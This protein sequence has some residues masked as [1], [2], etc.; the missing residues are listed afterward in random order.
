[1]YPFPGLI[2]LFKIEL[3]T[4]D[5]AIAFGQ[6]NIRV[7]ATEY[8]DIENISEYVTNGYMLPTFG[9]ANI[10]LYSEPN[11]YRS[12]SSV[13]FGG[14]HDV[15]GEGSRYAKPIPRSYDPVSY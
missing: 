9:P 8:L 3:C 12:A 11:N 10:D 15:I 6:G 7:L 2:R 5:E 14:A 1:M 4:Q 13:S